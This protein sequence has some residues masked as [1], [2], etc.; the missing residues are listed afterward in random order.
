MK[1][2]LNWLKDY[3]EIEH[4]PEEIAEIL[5]D[6]GLPCEGIENVG[7]DSIIDLEI[8]SNRGDCLSYI[9]VAREMAG[10]TGKQLKLPVV[11]LDELDRHAAE[12]CSVEIAEP[13]LCGRYTAR[14]IE[15]V[16]VGPSP[17]WM[18]KRL[19]AA[20]LRNVNNDYRRQDNS[21]ESCCRRTYCQ[22]R[23]YA[24]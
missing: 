17:D 8:T 9:G 4:S 19:E 23:R 15:G 22:H 10:A 5:S 24:M 21:Q 1:V 18:R 6:L 7:D 3:I 13:D 12:F 11:E 16:R 20:G 2:L 14:I